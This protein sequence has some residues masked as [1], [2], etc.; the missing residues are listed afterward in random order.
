MREITLSKLQNGESIDPKKMKL[1]IPLDL[2]VDEGK[3]ENS[4]VQNYK[5][6]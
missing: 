6:I 5:V 3:V 1:E 4:K 2:K